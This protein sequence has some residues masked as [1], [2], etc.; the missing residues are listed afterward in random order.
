MEARAGTAL[1]DVDLASWTCKAIHALALE[2]KRKDSQISLF[3]AHSTILT[4]VASFT[5]PE[6]TVITWKRKARTAGINLLQAPTTLTCTYFIPGKLPKRLSAYLSC[7]LVLKTMIN[8]NLFCN[9]F[10]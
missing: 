5:G 8:L 4:G 10:M 7:F 1:I 3:E 6:F 2:A 9:L